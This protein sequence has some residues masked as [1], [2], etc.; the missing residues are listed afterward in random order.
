MNMPSDNDLSK[1]LRHNGFYTHHDLMNMSEEYRE[2][3]D[4]VDESN[5]KIMLNKGYR[6]LVQIFQSFFSQKC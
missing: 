2:T 4:F 1:A 3:L 6:M 5:N